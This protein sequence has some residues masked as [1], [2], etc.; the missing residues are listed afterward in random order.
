MTHVSKRILVVD[1]DEEVRELVADVLERRGYD[2]VSVDNGEDAVAYLGADRPSVI[3]LDLRMPDMDGWE[4][5]GRLSSDRR[6]TQ[7]PVVVLT[8]APQRTWPRAVRCLPK[9][10]G[11]EDLLGAISEATR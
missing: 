10:F 8:G 4:V 7:I 2:V 6:W 3:L 11:T 1:D 5:L 9:P